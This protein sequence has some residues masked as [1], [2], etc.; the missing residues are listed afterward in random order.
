MQHAFSVC[1]FEVLGTSWLDSP[2]QLWRDFGTA[3]AFRTS[4][5]VAIGSPVVAFGAAAYGLFRA[6]YLDTL[7]PAESGPRGAP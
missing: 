4:A 6:G 7:A 3:G 1:V 5:I 2:T